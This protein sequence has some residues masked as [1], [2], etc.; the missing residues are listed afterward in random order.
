MSEVIIFKW[1]KIKHK[2]KNLNIARENVQ[3]TYIGMRKIKKFVESH[4]SRKTKMTYIKGLKLKNN[5]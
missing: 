3:S 4:V 1:L 5:P 2:K